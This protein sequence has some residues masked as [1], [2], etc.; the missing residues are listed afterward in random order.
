[1]RRATCAC[2]RFSNLP[3]PRPCTRGS[4]AAVP[5]WG[6]SRRDGDVTWLAV[7]AR[8]DELVR[9]DPGALA[10]LRELVAAELTQLL[11]A[12]KVLVSCRRVD[13]RTALYC[14]TD[15]AAGR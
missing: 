9:S 13:A 6:R 1:M 12:G 2:A 3:T 15:G 14:V 4:T 5:R 11:G 8:A 10:P 7:P